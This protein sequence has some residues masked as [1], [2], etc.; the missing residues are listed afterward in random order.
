MRVFCE[1][2]KFSGVNIDENKV[3]ESVAWL[4]QNQ[5]ASG[6]LPER[7]AVIHREMVV[8]NVVLLSC[9]C[10]SCPLGRRASLCS[11]DFF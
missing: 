4:I 9:L 1:A 11:I 3:C 8:R 5:D 6:A 10:D 7:N 2:K